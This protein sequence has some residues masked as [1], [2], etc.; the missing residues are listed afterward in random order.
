MEIFV[1]IPKTFAPITAA[2]GNHHN[3]RTHD[4]SEPFIFHASHEEAPAVAVH[5]AYCKA[6][7]LT[8]GLAKGFTSWGTPP[9]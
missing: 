7:C 5:A 9:V 2:C 8:K 4:L 1:A 6:L 3:F